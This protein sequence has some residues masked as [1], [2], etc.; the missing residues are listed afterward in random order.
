M[1]SRRNFLKKTA[2]VSL[3]GIAAKALSE[4]KLKAIEELSGENFTA[5]TF[6]LPVLPYPY[7]ALEPF[8]DKQTMELHHDKHHQAYVDKLNAALQTT[9][10]PGH[11]T[12]EEIFININSYSEAV[13]N[14]GGG[15]YN[16]SLF[17]SL[18]K[19]NKD[20]K[21]NVPTGKIAD[22]I[23]SSFTSFEEF[24]K[25]F[26]DAGMK[27]F[28]SGWAWLVV[29]DK[30]LK[31]CST[32]NQDNT[33]MSFSEAKGKPVL[34]LDVWEHAYYLKYQNKRADYVTNWWNVVN[35]EKVNELFSK[36]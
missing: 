8:I 30:K 12:L 27:R 22:A 23:N 36:A 25:Q 29:S 24:K 31:I 5:A 32:P 26:A 9:K 34:A 21:A 19:E 10:N 2:L 13:R 33:L 15:H 7:D 3:S 16:H 4:E 35:W 1:D 18:M 6:T 14:N 28:G 17:W 20:A 11:Q